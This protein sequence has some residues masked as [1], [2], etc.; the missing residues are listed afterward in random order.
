MNTSKNYYST[1]PVLVL[2]RRMAVPGIRMFP[3]WLVM[4]LLHHAVLLEVEVRELLLEVAVL[5]GQAAIV[6]TEGTE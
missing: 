3:R 4:R 6:S 5:R 2:A 1:D